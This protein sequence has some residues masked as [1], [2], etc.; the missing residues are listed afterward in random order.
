MH[1]GDPNLDSG[2]WIFKGFINFNRFRSSLVT[3]SAAILI[4]TSEYFDD[5]ASITSINSL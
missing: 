1:S 5:I 2:A 4:L 3:I